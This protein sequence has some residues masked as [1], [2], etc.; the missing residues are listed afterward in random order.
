MVNVCS[1]EVLVFYIHWFIKYLL[2]TNC[3]LGLG[4]RAVKKNDKVL[5]VMEVT[6]V[7]IIIS[8]II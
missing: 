7:G 2:N 1:L 3:M 4:D 6:F 5:V 8:Y